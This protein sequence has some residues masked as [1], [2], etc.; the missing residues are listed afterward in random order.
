MSVSTNGQCHRRLI[1]KLC[2][3]LGFQVWGLQ[4]TSGFRWSYC[5]GTAHLS[6]LTRH[7]DISVE[8]VGGATA[9][10]LAWGQWLRE[11]MVLVIGRGTSRLAP[12]DFPPRHKRNY[13]LVTERPEPGGAGRHAGIRFGCFHRANEFPTDGR[14]R[15]Q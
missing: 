8:P 4:L 2:C 15:M 13:R 1:G 11:T 6:R 10:T 3:R 9:V 14:C 7:E 5:L 12:A